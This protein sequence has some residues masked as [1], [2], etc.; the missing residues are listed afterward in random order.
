MCRIKLVLSG[1]PSVIVEEQAVDP[2]AAFELALPKVVRSL[3]RL[4]GKQDLAIRRRRHGKGAV[5][6]GEGPTYVD[7]GDAMGELIGRRVG[8]GAIGLARA[9]ARPE[10]ARRDAYLDTS[11]PGVSATSRRAGGGSTARR[12]TKATT[13]RAASALED[14]RTKPS[15]KSTRRGANRAKPSQQKE[16][17]SRDSVN[18]PA[19]RHNRGGATG[20]PGAPPTGRPRRATTTRM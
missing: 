10:Q 12:N 6:A 13:S 8:H 1:Q 5:L 7:P 4:M 11:Q 3:D 14:S 18:T 17:A 19:A 20:R 16:H 2:R 9:R 15:R